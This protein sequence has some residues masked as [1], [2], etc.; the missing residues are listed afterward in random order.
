[1]SLDLI[2]QIWFDLA[3]NIAYIRVDFADRAAWARTN[4]EFGLCAFQFGFLLIV[5]LCFV[6]VAFCFPPPP[7][8]SPK[9]QLL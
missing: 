3:F 2:W 7:P 5:A 8:P 9:G 1:M 4:C 6:L